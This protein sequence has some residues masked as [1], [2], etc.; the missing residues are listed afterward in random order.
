MGTGVRKAETEGQSDGA[1]GRERAG[2]M[3]VVGGCSERMRLSRDLATAA[4]GAGDWLFP[5]AG[6]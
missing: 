6:R 1:R 4:G 5:L 2:Q 3:G